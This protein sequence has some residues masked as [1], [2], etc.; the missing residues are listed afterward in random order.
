MAWGV[1]REISGRHLGDIQGGVWR[2]LELREARGGSG[3][4]SRQNHCVFLLKVARP[5]ISLEFWRGDPHDLRS[6]RIN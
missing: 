6:L 2:H 3:G 5:T 4:K 1:W